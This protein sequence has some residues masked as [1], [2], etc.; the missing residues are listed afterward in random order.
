M[1]GDRRIPIEAA[2]AVADAAVHYLRPYCERIEIAGS[3]RRKKKTIGDIEIVAI[4]KVQRAPNLF[5]EP[6]GP[7]EMLIDQGIVDANRCEWPWLRPEVMGSRYWKL[8]DTRMQNFQIDLF[9]VRPPAQWGPILAIRTGS[10][11]FSR[12]LMVALR[13]RGYRCEDGRV[14]DRK[15]EVIDCPEERDLFEA[16]GMRWIVPE[17]RG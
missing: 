3:I 6:S 8:H 9:L 5:G 1:G 2:R 15:G 14:L 4:P 13:A 11:D 12:R 16:A 10:A 17:S 7:E